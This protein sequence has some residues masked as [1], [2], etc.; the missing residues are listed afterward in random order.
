MSFYVTA[1]FP[2]LTKPIMAWLCIYDAYYIIQ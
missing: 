2:S 1:S